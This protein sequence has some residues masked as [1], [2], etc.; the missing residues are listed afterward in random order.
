MYNRNV[1][2]PYSRSPIA[3]S[4]ERERPPMISD[5]P[6]IEPMRIEFDSKRLSVATP[7]V[8]LQARVAE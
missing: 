3:P 5:T 6:P 1:H 8:L 2:G 7:T 4:K